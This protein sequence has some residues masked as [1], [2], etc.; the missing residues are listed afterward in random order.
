M[1]VCTI[2][3]QN[4]LPYARVLAASFLAHHPEG[5]VDVLVVDDERAGGPRSEGSVRYLGPFDIGLSRTEVHAMATIYDVTEYATALK[6]WLL[7]S[8]LAGDDV[9]VTYLDPDIR[10]YAPLDVVLDS[11]AVEGICF[12]PHTTRPMPRDGLLPD[13][14]DILLSGTYNLGFVSVD[15]RALGFLRWWQERLRRDCLHDVARGLFVD[16]RWVDLAVHYFRYESL[17]DEGCNVAYWN[18]D[19]RPLSQAD[20]VWRAGS[21]PLRFF[22]FSG[23]R[24][25]NSAVLS[26][27]HVS[28]ARLDPQSTESLQVL[29][30]EY[31]AA[32]TAAGYS[33]QGMGRYGYAQSL[34]GVLLTRT[35]RRRYRDELL[36]GAALPDPFD[37]AQVGAFRSWSRR[38]TSLRHQVVARVPR[39]GA[40]L[41]KAVEDPARAMAVVRTA[42]AARLA[43]RARTGERA[44]RWA[45]VGLPGVNVVG[46]FRAEDGVGQGARSMSACLDAAGIVHTT[47]VRTDTP[48]AQGSDFVER[49]DGQSYPID[50]ICVNADMLPSVVRD[51]DAS[52]GRAA[53]RI[54]VWAWEVEGF[55]ERMRAS[56]ALVDEVWTLSR[57]SAAAIAPVIDKPVLVFPY[58]VVPAEPVE[59]MTRADLGLPDGPLF[60]FCCDARS[61]LAR[62][63]PEAV[64]AAFRQAFPA[65]GEASLVIK[66]VNGGGAGV[67]DLLRESAGS[68]A[69]VHFLTQVLPAPQMAALMRLADCYVSLHRAEGLG[70]T[71]AEAMAE[72]KPVIATAYSGNL[73]F[74]TV[75]NSY[76]VPYE[77]TPVPPGCDPYEPGVLWANADIGAAAAA[78]RSVVDDPVE[79][80]R[81]GARARADIAA[82]MSPSARRDFLTS[83]M[84]VIA[85]RITARA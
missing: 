69:D 85:D 7:E 59:V 80:A 14:R 81:R 65:P 60:L 52:R 77:L 64:V 4:Y 20:G 70:F 79:A 47:V 48:S 35:L 58:P 19:Q 28:S 5:S 1:R 63:R 10:V 33:A 36:S 38:T 62:K 55:P 3:A 76:L 54:G 18:V 2:V 67:P 8:L 83:R 82:T 9:P 42:V 32:L 66:V 53:Y 25:E 84:S 45:P 31:T 61:V 46:Y 37:R 6:P 26:R 13:E 57:H 27:H 16:Q 34:D 40:K 17:R 22:H 68:R 72:G 21:G 49:D 71:M 11:V 51:L 74:M 75:G 44:P 23:Y 24:P 56:A 78:M 50:V 12:T 41:A 15:R 73:D 30:Q 39:S 29:C 43:S